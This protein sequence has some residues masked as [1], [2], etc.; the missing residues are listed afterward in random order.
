[1][2]VVWRTTYTASKRFHR[3]DSV[4]T[5]MP[6]AN[7]DILAAY[8]GVDSSPEASLFAVAGTDS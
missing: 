7:G 6:S 2:G 4:G 1:M 8:L 5:N 3:C